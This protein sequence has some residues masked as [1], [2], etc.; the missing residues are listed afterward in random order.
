MRADFRALVGGRDLQIVCTSHTPNTPTFLLDVAYARDDSLQVHRR[1]VQLLQPRVVQA[2]LLT[3]LRL[4]HLRGG[5]PLRR[6]H[7]QQ[8]ANEVL[9]LGAQTAVVAVCCV[10]TTCS[11]SLVGMR[12]LVI[13]KGEGT[14]ESSVKERE[15]RLHGIRRGTDRPHVRRLV[16]VRVGH[17]LR[18]PV[19]ASAHTN[20]H[21]LLIDFTR[22]PKVDENDVGQ[23]VAVCK[24]DVV[25]LDIAMD[26]V[27]LMQD[28]HSLDECAKNDL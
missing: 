20:G 26:D 19:H 10:V 2:L 22:V 7:Q 16:V 5:Q 24:H 4:A 13:P 17:N 21:V 15:R 12:I 11:D 23:I 1:H 8:R 3:P 14:R 27:F 28:D 9:R 18:S 6:V 25:G